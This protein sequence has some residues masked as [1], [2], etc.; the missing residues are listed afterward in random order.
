MADDH[1]LAIEAADDR[2]LVVGDLADPL[3]SEYLRMRSGLIDRLGVVRPAWRQCHVAGLLEQRY[4]AVP[5]RGEQP[6]PVNE[7]NGCGFRGVRALDLRSLVLSDGRLGGRDGHLLLLVSRD[8]RTLRVR[9]QRRI[10]CA[11]P[12]H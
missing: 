8:N 10:C 5:A 7:D 9:L 12:T 1:R 2:L 3:A 11:A 4:P 6:E